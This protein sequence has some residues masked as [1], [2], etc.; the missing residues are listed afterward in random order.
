MRFI[1][2][3]ATFWDK[4]GI[5][6]VILRHPGYQIILHGLSVIPPSPWTDQFYV[7]VDHEHRVIRFEGH[8]T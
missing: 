4:L 1:S 3:T 5:V 7:D 2:S 6:W 8:L